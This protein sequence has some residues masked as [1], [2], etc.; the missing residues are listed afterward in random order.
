MANKWDE[1]FKAII[2]D[3]LQHLYFICIIFRFIYILSIKTKLY[4]VRMQWMDDYNIYRCL[5]NDLS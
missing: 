3:D 2:L 5:T 1:Q 4:D